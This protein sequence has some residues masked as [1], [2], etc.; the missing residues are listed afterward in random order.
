MNGIYFRAKPQRISVKNW[1]AYCFHSCGISLGFVTRSY[2]F[3]FSEKGVNDVVKISG[4]RSFMA[5]TVCLW[6]SSSNTKGTLVSYA[7]LVSNSD[8]E[9]LVEYD[10]NFDFFIG[11]TQR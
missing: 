10:G 7:L 3:H 2:A 9:L 6:M 5:F 11:G 1:K 4:M 8:N